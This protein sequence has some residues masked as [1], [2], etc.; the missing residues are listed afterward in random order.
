M[1]IDSSHRVWIVTTA[2]LFLL[3]TLAYII[4]AQLFPGGPSGGTWPGL[5]FGI[6]GSA[7]MIAAGLL[8]ARKKMPTRRIGRASTWLKAHIWLGLLSLPLIV[9]HSAFRLGGLVEQLLWIALLT[10]IFSGIF[11]MVMQHYIPRAMSARVPLET[12][13]EQIDRICEVMRDEADQLV[14]EVCGPLPEHLKPAEAAEAKPARKKKV[15]PAPGSGPL[16]EFYL[17][18]VRTFLDPVYRRSNRLANATQSDGLFEQMRKRLPPELAPPLDQL[19][20]FCDERRQLAV[21]VRLHH[22]MHGWLFIHV[23]LSFALL[24][25]GLAHAIMALYY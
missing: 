22:W 3:A 2:I 7:L 1:L 9:Y 10:V 4:Y 19:S 6:L 17:R 12:I 16:K 24:G 11:G 8:S 18:Q 14:E 20:A 13:Y 23:P 21:Q 25:L 15:E 5:I